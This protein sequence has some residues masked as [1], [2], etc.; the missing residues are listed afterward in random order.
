[1]PIN[2]QNNRHPERTFRIVARCFSRNINFSRESKD[3]HFRCSIH[4]RK[5]KLKQRSVI[6]SEARSAES[7]DLHFRSSLHHEHQASEAICDPERS[8]Q[9]G[10]EEP[11]FPRCV[12]AR[13]QSCRRI[14]K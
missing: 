6:L 12:S 5:A 4:L 14:E 1:M 8:A 7:K 13:L 11:A 9:R 2:Q 10:I 3:L